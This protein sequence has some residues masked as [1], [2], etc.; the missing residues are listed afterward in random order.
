MSTSI[1]EMLDKNALVL[2]YDVGNAGPKDNPN[3]FLISLVS[4]HS[5]MITSNKTGKRYLF[6]IKNL[7]DL[8]IQAGIEES[9]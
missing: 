6:P 5:P 3:Q 1:G 4:F 2:T 7:I 9:E 8:A